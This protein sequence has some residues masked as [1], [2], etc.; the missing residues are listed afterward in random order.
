VEARRRAEPD[1]NHN[2]D[3]SWLQRLH[4][5]PLPFETKEFALI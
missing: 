5:E 1:S 3:V 2:N 4:E